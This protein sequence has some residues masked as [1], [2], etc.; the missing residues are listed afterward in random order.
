M[1]SGAAV[2]GSQPFVIIIEILPHETTAY[3]HKYEVFFYVRHFSMP[4]IAPPSWGAGQQCW[5]ARAAATRLF[6][7]ECCR[8]GTVAG[9]AQQMADRVP[10]R[11]GDFGAQPSAPPR[12]HAGWVLGWSKGPAA[13]HP[14]VHACNIGQAVL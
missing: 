11:V 4:A 7:R 3:V 14:R 5:P 6:S 13:H 9:R 8:P 1:Y 2:T 12:T 10:C